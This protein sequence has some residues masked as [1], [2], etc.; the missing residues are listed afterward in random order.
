M[1]WIYVWWFVTSVVGGHKN[2]KVPSQLNTKIQFAQV[3]EEAP[4]RSYIFYF[5]LFGLHPVDIT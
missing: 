2:S 3:D 4:E 5:D 1:Y